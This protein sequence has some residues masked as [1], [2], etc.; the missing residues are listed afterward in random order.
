MYCISL[1][2]DPAVETAWMA[3]NK[4]E[5]PLKFAVENE[6]K[7][8][9]RGV[10]MRADFPIYRVGISGFEY[11]I[12]YDKETIRIMAEKYLYDGFQNN[13]DTQHNNKLEQG[14]NLVQW[15]IKDTE[16]G[17]NPK[18][19]E[20]IEDGSLFAEYKVNNEEIWQQIKDGTFKGFSLAGFFDTVLVEEPQDEEEQEILNLIAK[21][22]SKLNK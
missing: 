13:V 21:I 20:D 3:F 4:D 22:K 10:I 14:V 12:E 7:H 9:V 16:N 1:V 6:D 5:Q 18:G 17:I 8:I 19:F 15:F 2:D 11:L